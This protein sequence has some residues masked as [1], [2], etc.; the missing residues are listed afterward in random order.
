MLFL[1]KVKEANLVQQQITLSRV[2]S[3][4]MPD[5]SQPMEQSRSNSWWYSNFN[6][7]GF[8][9]HGKLGKTTGVDVYKYKT[10]DGRSIFSALDYLII[11]A[12]QNGS[13]WPVRNLGGFPSSLTAQ[14]CK[15]AFVEVGDLRY[16]NSG[17][18]LLENKSM[19][20]NPFKLDAPIGSY[21]VVTKSDST[22][23]TPSLFLL[24]LVV[25]LVF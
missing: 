9:T 22:R 21:D 23:G 2:S 7:E 6:L 20:W 8:F 16:L 3:Q 15:D 1:G 10:V 4:I 18:K 5:G 13:N 17:Y 12:L 25:F 11:F 24:F 19:S 14:M